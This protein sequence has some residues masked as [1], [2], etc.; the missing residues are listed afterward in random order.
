MQSPVL[1]VPHVPSFYK[2][3]LSFQMSFLG[4]QNVCVPFC[5]HDP[6]M[7]PCFHDGVP[8]LV[9]VSVVH[10][11]VPLCHFLCRYSK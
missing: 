8:M 4:E 2:L 1:F 3:P 11:F 10:S 5:V 7:F 6:F 9:V